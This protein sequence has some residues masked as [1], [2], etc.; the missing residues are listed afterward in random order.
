[1]KN[2]QIIS[3]LVIVFLIF[4]TPGCKESGSGSIENGEESSGNLLLNPSFESNGAPSMKYWTV[5]DTFLVDFSPDVPPGGG[6]YS[7]AITA[8]WAPPVFVRTTVGA[9]T[10]TYRYRLSLWGKSE[11]IPGIV[12]LA[13]Q[14]PDTLIWLLREVI[15]YPADSTWREY[16]MLDTI[17]IKTSDK[18][19]VNLG[20]G[21]SQLSGGKTYYDLCS[22]EILYP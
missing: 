17:T 7:L 20:G 1:M 22:L 11:N 21:V 3:A 19:V 4:C 18:L 14:K 13:I 5:E 12:Y 16:S 10:G 6:S 8:D 15:I 2:R 9:P